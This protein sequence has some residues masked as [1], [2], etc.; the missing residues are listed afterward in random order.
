MVRTFMPTKIYKST[1][2][3]IF[4]MQSFPMDQ[5]TD[6]HVIPHFLSGEGEIYFKKSSCSK[7]NALCNERFEQSASNTDFLVPRL[8]L[9]LKRRNRKVAKKLP[10]CSLYPEGDMRYDDYNVTLPREEYP[11]VFSLMVFEPP[12]KVSKVDRGC[13]LSSLR[14][15]VIHLDRG[16]KLP[17][18]S[19]AMRHAHDHTAFS[20]TLAKIAYCYA[21]AELG[22]HGFDG[23]EIR[24]ILSGARKDVYNFVGGVA[25]PEILTKR[26]FHKLYFRERGDWL[27]V[28]VHLFAS[29]G[30]PPY[31]VV[32]G[33]RNSPEKNLLPRFGF[34][35]PH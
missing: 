27:T 22:I 1:G 21:V 8:L 32:V 9:D 16:K 2:Y 33:K 19:V 26:H 30:G 24:E 4:C 31:E 35:V 12:G 14:L 10:S 17:S 25:T 20:L 29:C 18:P 13:D 7:C 23:H 5:M 3:C 15:C 34:E 11:D 6:E 28:I